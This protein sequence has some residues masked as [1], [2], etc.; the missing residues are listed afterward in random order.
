MVVRLRGGR[1]FSSSTQYLCNILFHK[2]M[3]FGGWYFGCFS[4]TV[5]FLQELSFDDLLYTWE[6]IDTD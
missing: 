3:A 4:G 2:L 1:E 6:L 5:N